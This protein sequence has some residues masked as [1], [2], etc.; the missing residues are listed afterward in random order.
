MQFT[1]RK[2]HKT[3]VVII[4]SL[5]DVL[6][7]VLIFLMV[8]T[9]YKQ[10][11]AVKLAL[12]ESKQAKSGATENALIVTVA[13]QGPLYLGKEAITVQKL[14]ERLKEAVRNNPKTTLSIRADTDAPF[15]MIIKITDAAKAAHIV[16]VDSW[17]KAAQ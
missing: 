3:P 8:T 5:I 1:T 16:S 12:P 2:H 10:Q 15:G 14:E 17:V 11:P 6:I 9:T 4:V 7:V 13:R